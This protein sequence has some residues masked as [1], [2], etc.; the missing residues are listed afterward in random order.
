MHYDPCKIPFHHGLIKGTRAEPTNE[1]TKA[2]SETWQSIISYALKERSQELA[3]L[4]P[5]R[6][7]AYGCA[8]RQLSFSCDGTKAITI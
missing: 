3:K 1:G 8:L 2:I 6:E 4:M 7:L 5:Q